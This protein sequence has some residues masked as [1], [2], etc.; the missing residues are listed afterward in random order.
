MNGN[1][2]RPGI[3][4]FFIVYLYDLNFVVFVLKGLMVKRPVEND[5]WYSIVQERF[6]KA[7]V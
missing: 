7:C 1:R 2:R 5:S 3:R 6:P 4:F